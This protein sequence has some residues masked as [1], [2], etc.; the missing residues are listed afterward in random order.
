MAQA[1][2]RVYVRKDR[3]PLEAVILTK[4][5]LPADLAAAYRMVHGTF[6]D[7]AG[8]GA[9][10]K[11]GGTTEVTQRIF[12]VDELYFGALL[13]SEV[14][15]LPRLAPTFKTF[16]LKGEAEIA[17]RISPSAAD[18]LAEGQA[19]VRS[20]DVSELFD[21][22][23]V[24]LEL[25]SSPILN[26][27]DLGVIALVADRCAAGYLALGKSRELTTEMSW[28]GRELRIEQDGQAVSRGGAENLVWQPEM[29]ARL[30]LI[31]ALAQGYRPKPGQW[32]STGGA[33]PCVPFTKGSEIKV[34]FDDIEELSFVAGAAGDDD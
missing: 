25:P 34:F 29:C 20:A 3:T 32:I 33:T 9:A 1:N 31:E 2:N 18:K 27:V 6:G 13:D 26:L 21:R 11:L 23:C 8:F 4:S 30:F 22:W 7:V 19:A 12:N 10:W 17:L 5:E 15:V 28:S 24:A 16:E 14:A